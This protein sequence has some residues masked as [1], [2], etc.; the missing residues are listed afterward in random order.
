MFILQTCIHTFILFRQK[1]KLHT[2]TQTHR[3]TKTKQKIHLLKFDIGLLAEE[4]KID[5]QLIPDS[6]K[7]LIIDTTG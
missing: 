7:I 5:D 6:T 1:Q 3:K 4:R 2:N